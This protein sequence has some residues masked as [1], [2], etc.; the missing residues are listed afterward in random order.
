MSRQRHFLDIDVLTAAKD[1]I[2]HLYD[3]FDSVAV[4]FS[5]GKDSLVVLHLVREI[6][7]EMGRDH[8]EAFF[9]DEEIIP[10]AVIDFVD[11]YR[12]QP[13][14]NLLWYC[15]PLKSTKFI[16]AR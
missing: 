6:A 15:V 1:R 12:S 7:Q 13:W 16:L 10:D 11:G 9:Y 3:L 5:G 2:R 14:L 8:V 4:S